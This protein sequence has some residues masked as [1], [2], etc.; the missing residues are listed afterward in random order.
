ME[1][2]LYNNINQDLQVTEET[3]FGNL[4]AISKTGGI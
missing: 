4:S 3:P 1:E 2:L